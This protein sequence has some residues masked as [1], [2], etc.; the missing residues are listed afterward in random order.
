MKTLVNLTVVIIGSVTRLICMIIVFE[1]VENIKYFFSDMLL[2]IVDLIV[3]R[4]IDKTF[5]IKLI[6]NDQDENQ[7][8]NLFCRLIL[9]KYFII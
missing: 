2:D 3:N 4:E 5:I 6:G 7:V 1:N 9:N 8:Q